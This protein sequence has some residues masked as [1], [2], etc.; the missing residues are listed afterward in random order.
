MYCVAPVNNDYCTQPPTSNSRWCQKHVKRFG[1]ITSKYHELESKLKLDP[2]NYPHITPQMQGYT[3]SKEYLDWSN[4][5]IENEFRLL[6][7]I[8]ALRL[9]I[10]EKGFADGFRDLGHDKRL[11]SI[12]KALFI[13]NNLITTNDIECEE[14]NIIE[15]EEQLVIDKVVRTKTTTKSRTKKL[16]EQEFIRTWNDHDVQMYCRRE[17]NSYL[18]AC[19]R[20]YFQKWLNGDLM[21]EYSIAMAAGMLCSI[22]SWKCTRKNNVK[23]WKRAS[24]E[25][26]GSYKVTNCICTSCNCDTRKYFIVDYVH[27][28]KNLLL[29][30][31]FTVSPILAVM[32]SYNIKMSSILDLVQGP[33]WLIKRM[34]FGIDAYEFIKT[35]YLKDRGAEERLEHYKQTDYKKYKDLASRY[36]NIYYQNVKLPIINIPSI[37]RAIKNNDKLVYRFD[38][39]PDGRSIYKLFSYQDLNLHDMAIDALCQYQADITDLTCPC[40]ILGFAFV[41]RPL[42]RDLVGKYVIMENNSKEYE[43]S[44]LDIEQLS[45]PYD[46]Y[47]TV[48]DFSEDER[49]TVE[50]EFKEFELGSERGIEY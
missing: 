3:G 38:V 22:C 18:L 20:K 37:L 45:L 50:Q 13:L 17:I 10:R 23:M 21:F 8:Y 29:N 1:G 25:P 15:Q 11:D 6:W 9:K 4:E 12:N 26:L 43:V 5:E 31:P 2:F 35:P 30:P 28:Y 16:K 24:P 42:L 14:Y 39:S 34:D 49:K 48:W 41:D 27:V 32:Q 33:T 40:Q 7:K 36:S 19:L 47:L 44:D 46:S